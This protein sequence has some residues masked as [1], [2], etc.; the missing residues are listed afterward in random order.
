M[1]EAQDTNRIMNWANDQARQRHLY[2]QT[3]S[4][5]QTAI[6]AMFCVANSEHA[7]ILARPCSSNDVCAARMRKHRTHASRRSGMFDHE[8]NG[9]AARAERS[10]ACTL[11]LRGPARITRTGEGESC[12]SDSSPILR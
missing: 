9:V 7:D 8:Q 4:G 12:T 5:V 2:E 1:G 10:E 11:E 6:D 3:Y